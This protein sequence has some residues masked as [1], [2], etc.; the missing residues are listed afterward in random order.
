MRWGTASKR[1]NTQ[2]S[3]R[4][5]NTAFLTTTKPIEVSTLHFDKTAVFALKTT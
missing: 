2:S 1:K 5:N 4:Q 3:T